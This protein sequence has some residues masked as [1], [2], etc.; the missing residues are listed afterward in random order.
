MGYRGSPGVLNGVFIFF[1]YT[2]V[3]L[4]ESL[5]MSIICHH[6]CLEMVTDYFCCISEPLLVN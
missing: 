5:I 2:L 3:L 6:L 4:G 1:C